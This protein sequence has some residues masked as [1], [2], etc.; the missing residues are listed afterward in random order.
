M[1]VLEGVEGGEEG[2]EEGGRLGCHRHRL[3]WV[4]VCRRHHSNS[5]GRINQ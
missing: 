2:E 5:S 1:E 3:L 4:E